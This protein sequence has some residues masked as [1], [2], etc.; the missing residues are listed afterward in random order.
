MKVKG[1]FDDKYEP[2]APFIRAVVV[3]R[4]LGIEQAVDP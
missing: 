2:S 4:S 1:Y 3:S